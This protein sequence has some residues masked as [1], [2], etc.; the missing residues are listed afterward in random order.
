MKKKSN[1]LFHEKRASRA[2]HRLIAGVDEAGRGPLAGPVVAASVILKKAVFTTRI[3]DSKKLTPRARLTAYNEIIKKTH[4]G[5]GIVSEKIIDQINI[6]KAACLAME[7]AIKNL[8]IEPDYILIDGRMRLNIPQ[9]K[10]CIIGGDSK[11]FSI[12]CA[13]IIAKVTRDRIM[14]R[15]HKK[16][17]VYNFARHKGYGTKEHFTNLK[18]HGASPIHRRTFHPVKEL[19]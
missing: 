8:A 11:S 2:G 4:F 1:L 5:V 6:Y 15:Y 19:T 12:A 17:P 18:T 10:C 16:Y 3:D 7:K 9:K 13:S 14:E